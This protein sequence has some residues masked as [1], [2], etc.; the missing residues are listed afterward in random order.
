M[1]E[2]SS[3]NRNWCH[4]VE[5]KSYCFI[6]DDSWYLQRN[7]KKLKKKKKTLHSSR[8]TVHSW[9]KLNFMRCKKIWANQKYTNKFNNRCILYLYISAA[10][11]TLIMEKEPGYWLRI[12]ANED[13]IF[14]SILS[15]G[16]RL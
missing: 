12:Q 4:S 6:N 7:N 10:G 1:L 8:V 16:F 14:V 5:P 15:S 2:K 13:N 3:Q 11:D 9:K